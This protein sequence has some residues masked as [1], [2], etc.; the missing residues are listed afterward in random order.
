MTTRFGL[1]IFLSSIP[2]KL[3]RKKAG[4]LCHAASI[5]S[6]YVHVVDALLQTGDCT[7]GAIFGPQHGLYGQTQDNMIEWE[8][9]RHPQLDIPVYSL[10]GEVRRPR[11]EMLLGLDALIID[12]Q[13]VGA[14]PYTYVWTMKLCMEACAEAGIP[15]WVL[16]RPNPVAAMGFD[17]PMLDKGFFSF[18]GGARIPLCHRMTMGELAVLFKNAGLP[19]LDLQV[20]WMDGWHRSMFWPDTGLPWVLPSPNMPTVETALVYPGM[21]LLE[22]TNLSEGRGTTRPFELCGAPYLESRT[23]LATLTAQGPRGCVLRKHDFIP[24]FQKWAGQYCQGTQ[25]HVTDPRAYKPVVAGT[26]ILA[27]AIESSGGKFAF[28]DPPYEYEELK[29]PVDILSGDSRLRGCLARGGDL[30]ALQESWQDDHAEFQDVFDQVAHY[31]E[32]S[33]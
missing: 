3:R 9:Y 22:A 28:N 1:D 30:R 25:I 32:S 7:V 19:G 5:T 17:G 20:V 18:V 31:T 15:V 29:M 33:T 23:F 8:G 11:P 6:S 24:S 13:D 16:D 2:G 14:R 12:L 4:V 27:A 21:V 10:Y 26:D